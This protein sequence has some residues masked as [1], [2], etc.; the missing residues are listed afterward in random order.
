MIVLGEDK[1][2]VKVVETLLSLGNEI[3]L[4]ITPANNDHF[5]ILEKVAINNDIPFLIVDN[6]N[7]PDMVS[8]IQDLNPELIWLV[9][10]NKLIKKPILEIPKRGCINIH[11]ALLP[12]YRGQT[13]QQWA[14][15]H[16]E[17]E[18][19]IT[20]HF[21]DEGVDSGPIIVQQPILISEESYISDIQLLLY[22]RYEEIVKETLQ[23]LQDPSF[24]PLNQDIEGTVIYPKIKPENCF[25]TI[26]HSKRE[27]Y[28]IIRALSFP[29]FG[30]RFKQ[31][32]FRKGNILDDESAQKIKKIFPT[33][34]FYPNS[35][36]GDIFVTPDG[37]LEIEWFEE[38]QENKD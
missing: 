11:P 13:P 9:H 30:A 28:N 14:I 20:S 10:F 25:I 21:V 3:A 26:N 37:A 23:R 4:I 15:I 33:P 19:G 27:V 24:Q 2:S 32:I 18:I 29:Y 5:F 16:G 36:F 34:G 35:Q 22:Q 7:H 1:F 17:N 31:Y 12:K 6:I 8:H 38:H